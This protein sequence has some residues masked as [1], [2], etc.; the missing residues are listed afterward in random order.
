[1]QLFSFQ[2][3]KKRAHKKVVVKK[4]KKLVNLELDDLE[5]ELH[6]EM[7]PD[8]PSALKRLWMW[9]KDALTDGRSISFKLSEEAFGVTRKQVLFLQDIHALCAGGEMCGSVITVYIE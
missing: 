5:D 3:T 6:V 1:M 8:Y 7:G 2:R 9:A 4:I